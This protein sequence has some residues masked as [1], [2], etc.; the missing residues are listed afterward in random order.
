METIYILLSSQISPI[1]IHS[2]QRHL[3]KDLHEIRLVTNL[4]K[5]KQIIILNLIITNHH[6]LHLLNIRHQVHILT[7]DQPLEDHNHLIL[8]SIVILEILNLKGVVAIMILN[9]LKDDHNITTRQLINEAAIMVTHLTIQNRCNIC[10]QCKEVVS[11]Q[12]HSRR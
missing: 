11:I 5:L 4:N 9:L 8:V 6:H 10:N 1:V 2:L 7:H 3:I 12:D